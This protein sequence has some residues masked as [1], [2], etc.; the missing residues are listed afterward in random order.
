MLDRNHAQQSAYQPA[1]SA[2]WVDPDPDNVRDALDALAAGPVGSVQAIRVPYG[3]GAGPF[4]SV[5]APPV[6][7]RVLSIEIVSSVA[8]DAGSTLIVGDA[9]VTDRYLA[10]GEYVATDAPPNRF[11][12]ALRDT[13]CAGLPVRVGCPV[14]LVGEGVVVLEYVTPR[15]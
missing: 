13:A 1:V 9:T 8:N 15:V 7:A 6:G 10:A 11:D 14:N 5:A 4:F 2:D 3:P 12:S